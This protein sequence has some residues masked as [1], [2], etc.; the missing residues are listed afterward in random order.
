M[1]IY[2]VIRIVYENRC[3]SDCSS[4]LKKKL[5]MDQKYGWKKDPRFEKCKIR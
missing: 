2:N 1:C 3:S 5:V 4:G